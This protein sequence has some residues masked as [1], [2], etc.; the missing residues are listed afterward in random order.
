MVGWLPLYHD[1]GLIGSVLQPLYAGGALRADVAGR[2]PA[3][4]AALAGGDRRATAARR[5]GRPELRLRAVRRARSRPEDARGAR[6]VALGGGLQ[7]RRAG[8][9]RDARALRRGVRPQRLPARGASTPATAWPRR[10]CSS[11]AP[12]SASRRWSAA[13][14]RRARAQPAVADPEGAAGGQ[15]PAVAAGVGQEVA[16]VD[17]ESRA[18]AAGG[19]GGGDLGGRPERR[20]G[21]WSR[22]EATREHFPGADLAT[23][24]GRSC[25]P[26]TSASSPAASCSSPAAL[27]DLIIIRGRNH[28]PQ[29]IELTVERSHPRCAP[30]AAPP[31]A[32]RGRRGAAGGGAGDA[33]GGAPRRSR[34]GD[35]RRSAARW[36]RSTRRSSRRWC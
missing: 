28:Y 21:Y 1:M 26:A 34:R 19:G 9:R 36:P 14:T 23:A 35:A 5:V 13:S 6:P 12:A 20:P 17:P 8:A 15:R 18:P 29:D 31:S 27:K 2:V 33:A 7:R 24:R 22:P 3:A 25:A 10:R 4:P 11:P 30:A 16:I 32:S